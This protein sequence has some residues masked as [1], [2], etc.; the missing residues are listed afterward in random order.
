MVLRAEIRQKIIAKCNWIY[1]Q[2]PIIT[3]NRAFRA[4]RDY[5]CL[6]SPSSLEVEKYSYKKDYTNWCGIRPILSRGYSY[7]V[8]T[9]IL[10]I[11]C[12]TI[13][14][15]PLRLCIDNLHTRT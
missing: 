2:I 4:K 13:W 7:A 5:K 9:R 10:N 12:R 1:L 11:T 8:V 6:F 15:A 14:F 3:L